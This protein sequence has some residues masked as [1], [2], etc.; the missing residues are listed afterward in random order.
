MP[1]NPRWR[2]PLAIALFAALTVSL[3]PG[4][5]STHGSAASAADSSQSSGGQPPTQDQAVGHIWIGLGGEIYFNRHRVT[6]EQLKADLHALKLANGVIYYTR[7]QAALDPTPA[8]F[9]SFKKIIDINDTE[10]L[11]IKL[12][13]E[14][15]EGRPTAEPS[16]TSS[17]ESL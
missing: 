5:A 11:P 8:Q 3:E 2:I 4:C 7:D 15:P 1:Q 9:E 16:P 10:R 6:V 14:D 13:P 12:L 17:S